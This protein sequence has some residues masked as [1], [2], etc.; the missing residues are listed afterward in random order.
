M[1]SA[2]GD[3][4]KVGSS[5]TRM[6]SISVGQLIQISTAREQQIISRPITISPLRVVDDIG[7]S[8]I[9]LSVMFVYW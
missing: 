5:V 3:V 2:Q 9:D 6:L 1:S 7:I 8:K 4:N